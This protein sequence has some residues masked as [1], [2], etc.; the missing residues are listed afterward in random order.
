[1]ACIK[2]GGVLRVPHPDDARE[3]G[4]STLYGD[5]HLVGNVVI[6]YVPPNQRPMP[7]GTTHGQLLLPEQSNF[8]FRRETRPYEILAVPARYI[9]W[10][11]GALHPHDELLL[12]SA[13]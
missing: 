12:L 7:N 9:T 1:M 4:C 3:L 13:F 6:A 5:F 10:D 8:Y 2:T 11:A